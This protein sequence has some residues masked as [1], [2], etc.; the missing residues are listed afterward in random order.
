MR[1]LPRLQRGMSGSGHRKEGGSTDHRAAKV[2]PVLLLPGALSGGGREDPGGV[3]SPL[4]GD[5]ERKVSKISEVPSE[6]A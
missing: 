1:T 3:G 4:L 6:N 5:Q 2:H